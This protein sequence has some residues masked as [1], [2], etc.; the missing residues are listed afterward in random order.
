MRFFLTIIFFF[1]QGLNGWT[2]PRSIVIFFSFHLQLFNR[3]PFL[4]FLRPSPCG[5]NQIH[6]SLTRLWRTMSSQ[7]SA[8]DCLGWAARDSSGFLSPYKFSRRYVS[9]PNPLLQWANWNSFYFSFFS[10]CSIRNW[11]NVDRVRV[12]LFFLLC[13]DFTL[14]NRNWTSCFSLILQR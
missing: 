1:F 7:N 14:R 4:S 11:I 13:W 5:Q 9:S 10:G 3:I 6:P 2:P 8:E 12:S